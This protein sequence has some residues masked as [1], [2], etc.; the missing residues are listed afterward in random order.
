[1]DQVLIAG[2]GITG[3]FIGYT[4]ASRGIPA[5]IIARGDDFPIASHNNTGGINPLIGPGIPG[6]MA[7]FSLR[8]Y[9]LHRQHWERIQ[10]LS[11]I[12]FRPRLVS[13]VNLAFSA[14]EKQALLALQELYAQAPGFT[15]QWLSV[16]ELRER[17]PRISEQ[18]IGGL[19]TEGNATVDSERYTRAVL[20][21]AEALGASV[22]RDE[23]TSWV[24]AADRV[25]VQC[26]SGADH[27]C[28][29]LVLATGPWSQ[30][31]AAGA[32]PVKP[33]K[34]ELLLV[35]VD[36]PPFAFDI[37]IGFDGLNHYEGKRYWLGGTS[38]AIGFDVSA[39][40]AE[41]IKQKMSRL[42]PQAG[43]FRVLEHRAALRPATP[44][45][46][47]IVGRLA[48]RVLLATG[49]GAKGMLWSAGM[50]ELCV[51]LL[52]HEADEQA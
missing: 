47:P 13:R 52:C 19:L 14:A 2:G 34:G 23:V 51:G 26:A 9:Q 25:T 18:V 35:E 32:S 24:P 29:Q 33:V 21:A 11:G 37:A 49:A 38:E 15:A 1:M 17:E 4:L 12:D 41:L 16:A 40:S 6:P 8:A 22:L 44:D 39:A 46:L 27:A 50:A 20:Q 45:G 3:A 36:G 7:D 10:A 28:A 48:E 43:G 31:F 5:R 42:I 30:L